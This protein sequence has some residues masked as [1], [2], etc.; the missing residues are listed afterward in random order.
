MSKTIR[1]TQDG[2]YRLHMADDWRAWLWFDERCV[3]L[4]AA[5]FRGWF[6]FRFKWGGEEDLQISLHLAFVSVW[7][8]LDGFLKTPWEAREFEVS[9][10]DW[11]PSLTVWGK[12]NEWVAADPWWVRGVHVNLINLVLGRR[13]YSAVPL[14][15]PIDLAI[16]MPE[17]TYRA[18]CQLKECVWKRPRWPFAKRLKRA[19]FEIPGG[20]PF[21][22]K[23]ENSWDCGQDGIYGM[24]CPATTPEQ[25]IAAVV[26]SVMRN[27]RRHGG[28]LDW[29]PEPGDGERRETA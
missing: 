4:E 2:L 18:T 10:R 9:F 1:F 24:T 3:S 17:K 14:G 27:R 11:G 20:I 26:E 15:K 16:A 23:G 13:K 29:E 25:A 12:E 7:F 21:P 5:W 28:S 6:G 22:G 8:A 19:D